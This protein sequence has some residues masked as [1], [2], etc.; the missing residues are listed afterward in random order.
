MLEEF[1]FLSWSKVVKR[2]KD[3]FTM[4]RPDQIV[5]RRLMRLPAADLRTDRCSIQHN[6]RTSTSSSASHRELHPDISQRLL[7][8]FEAII[9]LAQLDV[10][11]EENHL[12][13]CLP[14]HQVSHSPPTRMLVSSPRRSDMRLCL[15]SSSCDRQT[16]QQSLT[17]DSHSP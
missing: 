7:E 4:T 9:Y 10:P 11:V 1:D 6:T 15:P 14:P 12:L 16:L 5:F 3:R 2:S 13:A 8:T 17:L